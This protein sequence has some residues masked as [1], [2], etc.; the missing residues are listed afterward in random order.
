M[1]KILVNWFLSTFSFLTTTDIGKK[2]LVFIISL[3]PILE[4][5]GGL[6]AASLLKIDLISSIIITFIGTILPVPFILLFIKK[7]IEWMG[8]TKKLKKIA[9]WLNKKAEKNKPKIDKYGFWGLVLFVGI[10]LPGTGAWTGSLAAGLFEMDFKKSIFA[11]FI[12]CIL[13]S[14]IMALLS[15]GVLGSLIN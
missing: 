13:A 3:L 15:Y 2:T 6:I 5:R 7:V 4:L 11:V 8:K 9:E 12:G 1:A 14:T 10:P